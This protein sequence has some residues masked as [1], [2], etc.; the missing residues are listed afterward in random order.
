M[1]KLSRLERI[2]GCLLGGA[3]G[4]AI[5]SQFEG[6][7]PPDDLVIADQLFVSDD[8]QLTIAT[9]EAIVDCGSVKPEE[10]AQRFLQWH[11]QRRF[12]GLGAST[13][14]S[15][16]E[17]DAGGHWAT[18]GATGERSAGNG[19]AMRIA[20]LAFFLDPNVDEDRRTIHDVCRITHRSDEAYVGALAV[21]RAIRYAMTGREFDREFLISLAD[22]LPDSRVRD[23]LR[24]VHDDMPSLAEYMRQFGA[25]GY[26]VD[27]I[28]LALLAVVQSADFM[29]TI[30]DIVSCGDDTDTVGSIFGQV[31]GASRGLNR[32]PEYLIDRVDQEPL[33]RSAIR[34]IAKI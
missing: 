18:V 7:P 9:C 3:L 1:S 25:S 26:V 24:L 16:I 13:L 4:D 31:F 23:R 33:I 27:S 11:R 14:K 20:P 30:H 15:L 12:S 6:Q 34:S 29:T 5:G 21:V 10:V 22:S 2:E 8:T 28:P 19:A 32:L 17:L